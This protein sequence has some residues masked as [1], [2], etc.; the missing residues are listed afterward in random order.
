M[1]PQVLEDE[2]LRLPDTLRLQ[3]VAASSMMVPFLGVVRLEAVTTPPLTPRAES[4][5]AALGPQPRAARAPV[6]RLVL[7]PRRRWLGGRRRHVRRRAARPH[8][9]RRERDV[10]VTR[11]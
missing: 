3:R 10:E 8:T 9:R 4:V 5:E 11:D 1:R 2:G 6:K 7:A